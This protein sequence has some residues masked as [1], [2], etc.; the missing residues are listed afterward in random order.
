MMLPFGLLTGLVTVVWARRWWGDA[1]GLLAAV[2]WCGCPIAIAHSA[3]VAHDIPAMALTVLTLFLTMKYREHPTARGPWIIGVLMGLAWLTKFST[4]SLL[5]LVPLFWLLLPGPI[6]RPWYRHCLALMACDFT[7]WIVLHAGYAVDTVTARSTNVSAPAAYMGLPGGFVAG[8]ERLNAII[9][10]PHPVFLNGEWSLTGFRTYYLM[11]LLYQLP[12]GLWAA[13]MVAAVLLWRSR[14]D[15]TQLRRGVALSTMMIAVLLPA[16]LSGNQ[17][18]LRYVFPVIPLLILIAAS[19]ARDWHAAT[20]LRKGIVC[21]AGLLAIV[22]LRFHPH[23]LSYFNELAGGPAHGREH[24]VDANLDWGQ[25]LHALRDYLRDH[26]SSQPL[27]L[28]YFGTAS[29]KL[30]GIDYEF[31]SA[32]QPQPGRFAI[33]ANFIAGRPHMLRD[34]DGR[35]RQLA[36]DELAPFRFFTP[37]AMMGYSIAYYEISPKDVARYHAAREKALREAGGL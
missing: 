21:G 23:H 13:I 28:A 26:P 30:L 14:Q 11:A 8:L 12:L 22:A 16:S 33:S 34:I 6:S 32:P 17:L 1:A 19:A 37:K 29:P 5:V 27:S 35:E 20:M 2:F 18:G 25:D 3:I 31:P 7:A 9:N 15:V 4:L 10:V 36:L 24:L